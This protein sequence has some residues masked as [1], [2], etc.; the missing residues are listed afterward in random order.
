VLAYFDTKM[1]HCGY[2]VFVSISICFEQPVEGWYLFVAASCYL[3]RP[4]NLLLFHKIGVTA[5]PVFTG[6]GCL[7][8]RKAGHSDLS[9]FP[10]TSAPRQSKSRK[11]IKQ[12]KSQTETA[13]NPAAEID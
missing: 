3:T 9:A 8:M 10:D 11:S 6:F 4:Y 1:S 12:S 5:W 2:F 13:K 7:H